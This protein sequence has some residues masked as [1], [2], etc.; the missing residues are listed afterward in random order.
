MVRYHGRSDKVDHNPRTGTLT[1]QCCNCKEFSDYFEMYRCF[2][3]GSW[4]C[5]NCTPDH[6]G[7]QHEPH[8]YHLHE[9]ESRIADLE[10]RLAVLSE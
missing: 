1:I 6:F 10:A 3:C 7:N 5:R 4:L 8:P 2:D 9:Y